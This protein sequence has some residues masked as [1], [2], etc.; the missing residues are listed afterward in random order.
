MRRNAGMAVLV[1]ALLTAGW[2]PIASGAQTTAT[3]PDLVVGSV[4]VQPSEPES[5][6]RIKFYA[7]VTNEGNES[8]DSFSIVLELHDA[9]SSAYEPIRNVTVE[10]LAPGNLT[11]VRSDF[12]LSEGHYEI[13]AIADEGDDV[14]ETDEQNNMA[15]ETF[16]V[17]QSDDPANLAAQAYVRDGAVGEP[18]EARYRVSN[19]GH[20]DAGASDVEVRL[21]GDVIDRQRIGS[22]DAGMSVSWTD[23]LGPFEEPGSHRVALIADADDEVSESYERDNRDIER[24]EILAFPDPAVTALTVDKN[25]VR[26][27]AATGPANPIAG[28]DVAV[29]VENIGQGEVESF[30]EVHVEAC[31]ED[32][33]VHLP[34]LR[35][36]CDRIEHTYLGPSEVEHGTTIEAEWDTTGK[37]GDW[38]VCAYL[39]NESLQTD[40]TNDERCQDT[41]VA[42]GGTGLGGIAAF[43]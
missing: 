20:G 36:T 33:A 25:R 42:V 6:E 3:G 2:G 21:D 35:A 7:N 11:S 39:E 32:G 9:N 12:T 27:D 30:T 41:F 13:H 8:A 18:T 26:T 19:T 22:L 5:G 40:R 37:A 15:V 4:L 43:G 28:Q 29:T 14:N 38:T 17:T 23:T 16:Q 34:P 10:T 31:P 24:F 1:V